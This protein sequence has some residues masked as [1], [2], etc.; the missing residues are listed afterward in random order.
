MATLFSWEDGSL[1]TVVGGDLSVDAGFGYPAVP[2]ILIEGN[3]TTTGCARWQFSAE[4]V[5]AFRMYFLTPAAWLPAG[6]VNIIQIQQSAAAINCAFRV[7]GQGNPGQCRLAR[8]GGATVVQSGSGVISL[9]TVYRFE[10]QN[11]A[12]ASEARAAVFPLLSDTP[13]WD[14]GWQSHADFGGDVTEVRA[15]I[16]STATTWDVWVD[17]VLGTDVVDD[18]IGRHPDDVS[19]TGPTVTVWNG[20]VE[21]PVSSVTVWDGADELAATVEV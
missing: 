2:A 17:S 18:W 13:L 9:D 3:G 7:G 5:V 1:P 12:A 20:S 4:P 10:L 15:G 8:T 21:L 19:V 16:A 6:A 11:D 14:S